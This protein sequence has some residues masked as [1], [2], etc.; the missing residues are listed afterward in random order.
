M[1]AAP[2]Q[3]LGQAETARPHHVEAVPAAQPRDAADERGRINLS[4]LVQLHWWGILGQAVVV[5]GADAVSGIE[6][7]VA[8]LAALLVL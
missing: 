7:P 8:T 6:L 4:W 5:V 2:A 1:A 3:T